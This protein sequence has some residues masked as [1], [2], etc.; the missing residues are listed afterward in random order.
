MRE[1]A[2]VKSPSRFD[3]V[4]HFGGRQDAINV[5]E[6]DLVTTLIVLLQQQYTSIGIIIL[7]DGAM[8]YSDNCV[9]QYQTNKEVEEHF[10]LHSV[11]IRDWA[12]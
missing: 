11:R 4:K 9:I 1:K 10:C 5:P 7:V 2:Y 6:T 12:C 3:P 8:L